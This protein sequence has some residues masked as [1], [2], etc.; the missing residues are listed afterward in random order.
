MNQPANLSAALAGR[1]LAYTTK[2]H[3]DLAMAATASSV[4]SGIAVRDT[5][6]LDVLRRARVRGYASPVLVDVGVWTTQVASSHSPTS[7]DAPSALISRIS[8]DSWASPLLRAGASVV[9]TPS[10]F[11]RLA[12]WRSLRAVIAAG[13]S[14]TLPEVVTLVATDAA[15]L[16]RSYLPRFIRE[17]SRAERS[18]ALIFAAKSKPLAHWGRPA[19]L[20][21]VV[22]A[23]ENCNLLAVEPVTAADVLSFGA[24]AAAIGM[25]GGL[26]RPRCPGDPKGGPDAHSFTPGLFLRDLW[27]HRS[28]GTYGDWFANSPSPTCHACG[29]RALDVFGSDEADKKAV[30]R[31]NVHAWLGVHADLRGQDCITQRRILG[32]ERAAALAAHLSL[33]PASGHLEADPVLRQL[34]ELDDPRGRRTT[35]QG[36]WR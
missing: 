1:F 23:I 6:P 16:D 31:H 28:S 27:E 7:L 30:L 24:S 22:S 17:L 11:V 26:R 19:G 25:T 14:A 5:S 3:Q 36:A 29:G 8:L 21:Q 9:L 34:V 4:A 10:K 13:D 12:D 33:R 32:D 18:V 20:R 2:E 15:M 35:P